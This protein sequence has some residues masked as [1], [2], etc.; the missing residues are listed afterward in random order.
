M[1]PGGLSLA[2]N[3]HSTTC[4]VTNLFRGFHSH[5]LFHNC[6]DELLFPEFDEDDHEDIVGS[7]ANLTNV[8]AKK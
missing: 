8:D 3:R 5:D 1:P 6:L 4:Q 2:V 7:T